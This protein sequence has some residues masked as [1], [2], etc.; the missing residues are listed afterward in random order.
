VIYD[1]ELYHVSAVPGPGAATEPLGPCKII[2]KNVFVTVTQHSGEARVVLLDELVEVDRTQPRLTTVTGRTVYPRRVDLPA[3][4]FVE[5]ASGHAR[6]VSGDRIARLVATK[7]EGP[8]GRI[9]W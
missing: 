1:V 6:S 3:K 7:R 9:S 5:T 2:T 4:I 8:A